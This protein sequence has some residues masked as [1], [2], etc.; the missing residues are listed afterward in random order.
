M[1]LSGK[2][3]PGTLAYVYY[4]GEWERGIVEKV[5]RTQL[6]VYLHKGAL[7]TVPATWV[8]PRNT[9]QHGTDKPSDSPDTKSTR[10]KVLRA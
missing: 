5:G 10:I 8:R 3:M 1:K 7:V 2:W 4:E 6:S 9:H